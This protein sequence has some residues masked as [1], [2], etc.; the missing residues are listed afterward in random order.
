[1]QSRQR[2]GWQVVAACV[3]ILVMPAHVD[4]SR[5]W[6]SPRYV[7]ALKLSAL[8][9]SAINRLF[10]ESIHDCGNRSR[11]ARA[12]HV[13]LNRLLE[14][15]APDDNV[16]RAAIAAIN[17]DAEANKARAFLLVRIYRVLTP[18]QRAKLQGMARLRGPIR[19]AGRSAVDVARPEM[20][21][22]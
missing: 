15:S 3:L 5:W 22:W 21:G 12:A 16:E 17:A 11:A 10:E 6:R 18:R 14:T 20:P 9:A 19:G 8:Q 7:A 1:M 4:S 2:V 13:R